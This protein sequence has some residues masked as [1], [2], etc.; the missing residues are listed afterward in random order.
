MDQGPPQ[1]R[2][3]ENLP[4][5]SP[6]LALLQ[7]PRPKNASS[8]PNPR[9]KRACTIELWIVLRLNARSNA[10]A[11]TSIAEQWRWLWKGKWGQSSSKC[12]LGFRRSLVLPFR[13]S[14]DWIRKRQPRLTKPSWA[15]WSNPC[16]ALA[17]LWRLNLKLAQYSKQW[18]FER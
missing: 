9:N 2:W 16:N 17:K 15:T 10:R 12:Q 8:W 7:P 1:Q 11:D 13:W 14:Q 4:S 3:G 6:Q 18:T 5:E